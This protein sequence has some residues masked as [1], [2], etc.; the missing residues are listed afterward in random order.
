MM[1]INFLTSC[2]IRAAVYHEYL[3]LKTINIHCNVLLVEVKRICDVIFSLILFTLKQRNAIP[4][5]LEV[6]N[7]LTLALAV[8]Y[9][10]DRTVSQP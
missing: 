3:L 2:L 6:V 5:M 4:T 8:C 1:F 10:V 9:L 7:C